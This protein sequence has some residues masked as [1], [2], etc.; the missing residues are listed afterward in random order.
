[1][2][3]LLL[4]RKPSSD[5]ENLLI[6]LPCQ[7]CIVRITKT[8]L[9][10]DALLF[11]LRPPS[12][13]D[14]LQISASAVSGLY[15]VPLPPGCSYRSSFCAQSC[16][17]IRECLNKAAEWPS[18]PFSVALK[19][20]RRKTGSRL[21]ASHFCLPPS[22]LIFPK[23]QPNGRPLLFLKLSF[24]MLC[25]LMGSSLAQLEQSQRVWLGEKNILERHWCLRKLLML[26]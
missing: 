5:N 25:L 22:I 21:V 14:S 12:A 4:L 9:N 8:S 19:V 15:L 24:A 3:F 6:T 26:A 7:H 13:S 10:I 18:F 2:C 17:L 11:L 20:E 23:R 1:M 16:A